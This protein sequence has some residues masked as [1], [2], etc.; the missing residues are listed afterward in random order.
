MHV[1]NLSSLAI[2][3]NVTFF[4]LTMA[5]NQLTPGKIIHERNS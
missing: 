2:G 5:C 3:K 1:K 4:P